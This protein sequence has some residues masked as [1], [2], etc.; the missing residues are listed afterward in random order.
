MNRLLR[1]A[2][3]IAALLGLAASLSCNDAQASSGPKRHTDGR[4]RVEFWHAMS[5]SGQRS[6]N[7][8]ISDFNK[9]QEKYFVTGV[10]QGNYESLSQKLIASLYAGNN[11]AAS[12]MYEGWAARYMHFGYLQPVRHFLE[13][14]PAY[15]EELKKDLFPPF[16]EIGTQPDPATGEMV[17]ATLPF[18]KSVYMLCINEDAMRA[19]GLEAPRT[20]AEFLPFAQKLSER[21]GQKLTKYGF[22]TRDNTE[23]YVTLLFS[24]GI[25]VLDENNNITMNS[26][27]GIAALEFL[28][29]LV[30][31]KDRSGYVESDYLSGVF[32]KGDVRT[33]ISST[34][35]F[36]H[37]DRA[38][39][40]KFIWRAYAI[41][42]MEPGGDKVLSQGTSI[43]IFK[44]SVSP[45]EQQG[46]W[47]FFRYLISPEV[48]AK[49]CTDT[50]YIP[51][52]RSVL[53]MPK[54]KE[55]LAKDASMQNAIALV[56]KIM[57]EPRPIYWDSVRKVL[58]EMVQ[59]ALSGKEKPKEAIAR[60]TAS[61]ERIIASEGVSTRVTKH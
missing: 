57:F 8:L 7:E 43:G 50:A 3:L 40:N 34:P 52:R 10:Y 25:N 47:E 42:A 56:D 53:E 28:V 59:S 58:E 4:I 13:Q 21:T 49:W 61:I 6:L 16:Y 54:M 5:S 15:Y 26:S 9:S 36:T 30:V 20:W 12:Q 24:A 37:N 29:D 32:G 1:A 46:A 35:G 19:E 55:Y 18:N 51:I 38:V 14:D 11:P 60:A 31:G 39:A 45:E 48:Q 17:L 41:P 44:S 27:K 2:L 33:Y 23:A 22:A